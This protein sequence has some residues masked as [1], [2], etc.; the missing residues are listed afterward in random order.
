MQQWYP[1]L[2]VAS[3][4]T[5]CSGCVSAGEGRPPSALAQAHEQ[6][7][8][9]FEVPVAEEVLDDARPPVFT[10]ALASAGSSNS[11]RTDDA[12]TSRSDASWIR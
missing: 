6:L 11:A 3:P 4:H 9:A 2:A 1:R 10:H 12:N 7:G 5:S 8:P